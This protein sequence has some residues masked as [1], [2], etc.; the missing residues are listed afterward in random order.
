MDKGGYAI[1]ILF[2]AAVAMVAGSAITW[3]QL[4]KEQ[5]D[6]KRVITCPYCGKPVD[7]DLRKKGEPK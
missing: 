6:V 4:K 2:V 7:V 1:T 5:A 3:V